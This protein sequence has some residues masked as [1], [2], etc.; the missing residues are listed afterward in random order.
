M[1]N[2]RSKQLKIKLFISELVLIT[3]RRVRGVFCIG[4]G[5]EKIRGMVYNKNQIVGEALAASREFVH[6]FGRPRG[7][8]LHSEPKKLQSFKL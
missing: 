3:P 2:S 5:I 8:T 6:I 1:E 7:S 4:G